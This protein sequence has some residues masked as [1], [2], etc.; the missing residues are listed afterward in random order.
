MN[1]FAHFWSQSDALTKAIVYLLLIMSIVSWY[2]IISKT[3]SALQRKKARSALDKFWASTS[4]QKAVENL[5]K[6]DKEALFVSLATNTYQS[7]TAPNKENSLNNQI[8]KEE[9][10]TRNLRQ[11]VNKSTI[12]MEKG[13]TVLASIGA[14]SP[15]IGLFGTVWGIYHALAAIASVNIVQLDKIAGPVGESL[16]MTAFGLLVA[17]PA[18]IAYNGF[19]RINRVNMKELDGFARD[20]QT[21]FNKQT[22]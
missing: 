22:F 21:Y 1:S 3:Y 8:S 18:V 16:I 6:A 9:Q 17:I 14:T 20:L 4:F 10:I 11:A 5:S 12:R 2:Y 19:N 15:F 13:Q 7:L